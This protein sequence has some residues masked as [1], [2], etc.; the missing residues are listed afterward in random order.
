[1]FGK[2]EKNTPEIAQPITAR[3]ETMPG[4][5]YAG[6]DPVIYQNSVDKPLT[7]NSTNL[8]VTAPVQKPPLVPPKIQAPKSTP[9]APPEKASLEK[10][11]PPLPSGGKKKFIFIGL[12][13]LLLFCA[14]L[15][16]YLYTRFQNNGKTPEIPVAATSS[17]VAS[18]FE[19]PPVPTSTEIIVTPPTTTPTSTPLVRGGGV[20][21]LPQVSY[22]TSRDD[23][24]DTLTNRE[25][26]VFVTDPEI[27]DTDQDGYYDGLEII[28][29]YNPKGIAP[30]KII[31]SGLV[32]EY[33]NPVYQY[34]FYYPSSW[35][36]DAVAQEFDDILI[37]TDTGDYIEIRVFP[38]EPNVTF[39]SW[40]ST[41]LP[42]ENFL[43]LNE[44]SNRFQISGYKRADN[45]VGFFETPT[46][47]YSLIYFYG[48]EKNL[49]P[50]IMEIVLQSFRPTRGG[51]DL[52]VQPILP[53]I[54]LPTSSPVTTSTPVASSTEPQNTS[55]TNTPA[56]PLQE[57]QNSSSSIPSL[58]PSELNS[59]NI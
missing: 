40:F 22:A 55:A 42:G 26:E 34:R 58:P 8:S 24:A 35:R 3:I 39:S 7:E 18:P 54:V 10:P 5:F 16:F 59:E 17:F 53:G 29:L 21:S 50:H 12:G 14:V 48:E 33:I 1:M 13:V 51:F 57:S 36:V 43:S 37:S 2:K 32:R 28:N 23:D 44:F 49:F 25:E 45:Q 46:A 9:V 20:L 6:A 27:W 30:Q 19:T 52:P 4:A 56:I 15:G 11:L 47:I 38:K 31:D 41:F